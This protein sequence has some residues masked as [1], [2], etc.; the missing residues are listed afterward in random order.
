MRID[1]IERLHV[2]PGGVANEGSDHPVGLASVRFASVSARFRPRHGHG[3][4]P[5]DVPCRLAMM[6][7]VPVGWRREIRP[8]S[9]LCQSRCAVNS[10]R[11]SMLSETF[12]GACSPQ[13]WKAKRLTK[14][15]RSSAR[16]WNIQAPVTFTSKARAQRKVSSHKQNV[17]S[18]ASFRNLFTT[19]S[20]IPRHGIYG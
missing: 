17:T 7:G 15:L 12:H 9:M 11:L 14:H 5:G 6:R 13:Q 18:S 19:L 2:A 20:N 16:I 1:R 4:G 8:R 3:H 10:T